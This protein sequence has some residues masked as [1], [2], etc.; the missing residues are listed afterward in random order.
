VLA[1]GV[2][3]LAIAGTPHYTHAMGLLALMTGAILVAIGVLRLGWVAEFLSLP[4]ITGVLAGI[5]IEII[6]RQ[7]PVVLGLPP[8][9]TTTVARLRGVIDHLGDINGWTVAISI[10]V[11]AILFVAE[12]VNPRIPGALIGLVASILV[13]EAGNLTSH[14]VAVLGPLH[15]GLPSFGVPSATW[16]DARHLVA[17]ALTV[18]FLCVAQTAATVRSSGTGSMEPVDFNRDLAAVGAGSLA[19]GLCGAFAVDSSPPRTTVVELSGGRTQLTSIFAAAVMIVIVLVATGLLRNLPEATL[20]AILIFVATRL[21]RVGDL[22]AVLA[23][24]R[25]EFG[26]AIVTM[27]VVGFVGI[28]QGLVVAIALSLADRT[29]R[30]ARPRYEVLGREPGTVHWVPVDVGR[31]TE[32]VPGVMVCIFYAP[33]WYAN[34]DFIRLRVRELVT[35]AS[36]PVRAFVLDADATSDVDFT[37]ARALADLATDLRQVGVELVIARASHPVHRGLKHG[38]VLEDLGKDHLFPSVE[39]AVEA[40]SRRS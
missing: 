31:P 10:G 28:E 35:A 6:A 37:G 11:L 23:F 5:A 16:G 17:P 12:R 14:G 34:A 33:I 1:S 18:A 30:V 3:A 24:K 9:G 38:G 40:V 2:A 20:G 21:F 27:L 19:A 13:V 39:D 32:Q 29:R 15:G 4:V 26:L 36:P 22:R 25:L 7:L 8:E